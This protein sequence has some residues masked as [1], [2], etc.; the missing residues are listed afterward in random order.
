MHLR[1]CRTASLQVACTSEPDGIIGEVMVREGGQEG[2]QE[3]I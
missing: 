1:K 3:V 2:G